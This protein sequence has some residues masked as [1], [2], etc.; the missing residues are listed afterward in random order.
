MAE[1]INSSLRQSATKVVKCVSTGC[2]LYPLL[3]A[4][5]AHCLSSGEHG[6]TKAVRYCAIHECTLY[7][8]RF[9]HN[10]QRRGHGKIANFCKKCPLKAGLKNADA[11]RGVKLW[12]P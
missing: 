5:R 4:I 6:S 2:A 1:I 12:I 8:Y 10:P 9:G 3:K 11:L 7:S